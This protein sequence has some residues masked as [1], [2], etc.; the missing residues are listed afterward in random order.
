MR[1]VADEHS[2]GVG[3]GSAGGAGDRALSASDLERSVTPYT[4]GERVR[5]VLWNYVGQAAFRLTFHNWYGCRASLL[6]LFG[7]RIGQH[8]RIR[9]TVL[10]EQPWNLTIGD[11]TSVGDR[12]I[13]YCL[14]KVTL[15]RNV[16]LSQMV[17]LCAGTHDHT[18]SD[19]P[20]LRP[21]IEIGDEVWL[22]ADVFVGPNVKIGEGCVVG[23]R[24]SVFKD[25]PG[26]TVCAGT[27]AR[28]LKPRVL[29]QG[30]GGR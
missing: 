5:R 29:A 7:A 30:E 11:N 3:A 15:G 2:A 12:S 1:S 21:P 19:L 10:V 20:L 8:T 25:L 4:R 16:S 23:A 17:H 22:A 13:L 14:G 9:P 6:R 26:W 27:P 18:R 24:S 28:A